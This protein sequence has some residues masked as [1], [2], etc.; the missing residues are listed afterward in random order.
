MLKQ[1]L[2]SFIFGQIIINEI[3][4]VTFLKPF[5]VK[6]LTANGSI[7]HCVGCDDGRGDEL[8]AAE[9][10]EDG[11]AVRLFSPR[12]LQA[13]VSLRQSTGTSVVATS[14]FGNK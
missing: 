4:I 12:D 14:L 6:N 9:V 1:F 5:V 13:V 10:V 7:D 11:D 3:G 8:S 2:F